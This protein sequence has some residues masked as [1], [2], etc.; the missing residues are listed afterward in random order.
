MSQTATNDFSFYIRLWVETLSSRPGL[1][2]LVLR[3]RQATYKSL[4]YRCYRCWCGRL[5][6]F[7]IERSLHSASVPLRFSLFF[8]SVG[9][10]HEISHRN[11]CRRRLCG[12]EW[13]KKK[14]MFGPFWSLNAVLGYIN[15]GQAYLLVATVTVTEQYMNGDFVRLLCEVRRRITSKHVIFKW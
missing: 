13:W 5:K 12:I 2:L 4:C 11:K 3:T 6:Q 15:I 1:R 9:R 8:V 7:A 10:C 14:N